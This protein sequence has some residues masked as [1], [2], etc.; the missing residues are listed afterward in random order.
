MP[1]SYVKKIIADNRLYTTLSS[2]LVWGKGKVTG[3]KIFSMCKELEYAMVKSNVGLNF[4]IPHFCYCFHCLY[5]LL[6][7]FRSFKKNNWYFVFMVTNPIK[8]I[9]TIKIPHTK[10]PYTFIPCTPWVLQA[11]QWKRLLHLPWMTILWK[12]ITKY[13]L[14]S[15]SFLFFFRET[16]SFIPGFPEVTVT[17]GNKVKAKQHLN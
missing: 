10:L 17:Y 4:L 5:I 14:F 2:T 15:F 9:Q 3:S 16:P 7:I 6:F 1:L 12:D 8:E 11:G 13:I